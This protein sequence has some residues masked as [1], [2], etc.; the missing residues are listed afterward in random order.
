MKKF[1][2]TSHNDAIAFDFYSAEEAFNYIND[3]AE[4][5]YNTS[6]WS[7]KQVNTT[8]K[9]ISYLSSTEVKTS[10][11]LKEI[12]RDKCGI[13]IDGRIYTS[14]ESILD[15][16]YVLV[17]FVDLEEILDIDRENL[18]LASSE[19]VRIHAMAY[20]IHFSTQNP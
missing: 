4:H 1:I 6:D 18:D 7:V 13:E 16:G 8:P 14:I 19:F 11:Q 3:R 9:T 2:V 5:G 12:F 10:E 17:R 15:V 20:A